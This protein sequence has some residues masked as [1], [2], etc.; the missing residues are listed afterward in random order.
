MKSRV[1]L[2]PWAL[3]EV[4][5]ALRHDEAAHDVHGRR[6][7]CKGGKGIGHARGAA[8]QHHAAKCR[9]AGD[10]VGHGHE[11]RV[12]RVLHPPDHLV[13]RGARQREGPQEVPRNSSAH[14]EQQGVATGDCQ[15]IGQVLPERAHLLLGHRSG[16]CGFGLRRGGLRRWRHWDLLAILGAHNGPG[17]DVALLA[18]CQGGIDAGEQALGLLL[19]ADVPKQVGQVL[20]EHRGTLAGHAPGQVGVAQDRHAV[21]RHNHFVLFREHAV[22]T[23]D[24][25]KVDNDAARLHVLHHVLLDEHGARP[26][27][28]GRGGDHDLALLQVL[29]EGVLLRLLE[30]RAALFGV[31]ALAGAALLEVHRDPGSPHGLHLVADVAH[32]P[33]AHHGAHGLGGADG[34]QARHA[35]AQDHGVGRRV[36]AGRRHLRRE[37]TAVDVGSLQ[38]SPVPRAF[39]LRREH[40]Q[41]LGDGDARHRGEVHQLHARLGGLRQQLLGVRQAAAHPRH[42]RLA[43]QRAELGDGRRV[44]REDQL[45]VLDQITAACH[46]AANILVELVGEARLGSCAGLDIHSVTVL[47]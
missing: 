45:V 27:G 32:V 7:S 36:L 4:Q 47:D 18:G 17:D 3:E 11:R 46:G 40:V 26:A 2:V 23:A 19:G 30:G 43:L 38:D 39:G 29:V 41:L 6:D 21:V 13:A 5:H 14:A 31:P 1:V 42:G 15:G 16:G 33:G 22:A 9:G 34:R 10:G 44:D 28:D 24:S 8:Q 37:E 12:Q 25:C 35:H 20:S